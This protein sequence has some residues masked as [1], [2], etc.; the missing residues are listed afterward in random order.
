MIIISREYTY[1]PSSGG[2][3]RTTEFKVFA[4][5]DLKGIQDYLDTHNGSFDFKKL[6]WEKSK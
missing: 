5:D 2:S 3:Y 6:Q 4:D 1:R